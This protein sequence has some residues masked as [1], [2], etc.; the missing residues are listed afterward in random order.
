MR[1]SAAPTDSRGLG[2]L[3][4]FLVPAILVACAL[5]GS[6]AEGAADWL[7]FLPLLVVFLIVPLLRMSGITWEDPGPARPR[8]RLSRLY[9]RVLPLAAVPAQL[10]TL[11]IATHFWSTASLHLAGRVGWLLSIGIFSA[12]FAITVAHELIH[13]RSR[14]DR[15]IG[16]LLLSTNCFGSFK[17]VHLRVHHRFVGTALDFSSARRGESIYPFWLRCLYGNLREALR[18]ERERQRRLGLSW[19]RTE[20]LVWY[21]FSAGWLALSWLVWSWLGALFF[22]LQSV[23]AILALEWTNYVQHYG[24]RRRVDL[25]GRYEPVRPD[26]AW[27]MECRIADLA[28]LNLLRHGDHHTH[29]IVP[30]YARMLPRRPTLTR[31]AS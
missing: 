11:G 12:L 6:A 1:A 4:T 7:A 26:H 10:A 2:Y 24:L 29:P 22:L 17:I 21:G 15:A 3:L 31:S 9:Y 8:G 28:L 16:G 13:H 23:V 30:Y 19:W 27:K 18:C 25:R 14:L 5:L 20:L